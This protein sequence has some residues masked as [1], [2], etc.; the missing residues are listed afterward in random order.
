MISVEI[1]EDGTTKYRFAITQEGDNLR[2]I[3]HEGRGS[4]TSTLPISRNMPR[5]SKF[6]DIIAVLR[7]YPNKRGNK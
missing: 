1:S 7:D 3:V 2:Y 4:F 5:Q 6:S